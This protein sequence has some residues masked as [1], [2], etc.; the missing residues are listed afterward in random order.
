MFAADRDD[1][2]GNVPDV[3][4][5]EPVLSKG[6]RAAST[7]LFHVFR[8]RPAAGV[9]LLAALLGSACGRVA[10]CDALVANGAED[11]AWVVRVRRDLPV[12]PPS[13]EAVFA[14][15]ARQLAASSGSKAW[16]EGVLD[17]ANASS[18]NIAT[19]ARVANLAEQALLGRG[20][21]RWRVRLHGLRV[22]R[23]DRGESDEIGR[24]VIHVDETRPAVS[25]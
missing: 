19:L 3:R 12:L 8:Y 20:I 15:I 1:R 9:L 25:N 10:A 6:L 4:G 5:E 17:A 21:V 14:Q 13:C 18:M 16:I 24:I 11:P 7:A 23:R 2:F 22:P